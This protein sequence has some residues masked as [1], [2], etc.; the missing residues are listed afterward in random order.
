MNS[1]DFLYQNVLIPLDHNVSILL[2][3]NM[4]NGNIR[5]FLYRKLCLETWC[6]SKPLWKMLTLLV[7]FWRP[8][9]CWYL[10]TKMCWYSRPKCVDSSFKQYIMQLLRRFGLEY[11]AWK[12]TIVQH[13]ECCWFF[14]YNFLGQNFSDTFPSIHVLLTSSISL[15]YS[16]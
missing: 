3:S 12:V 2:V 11:Y 6:G 5:A 14:L 4:Y 16:S 1:T 9:P 13:L 10:Q 8:K 7:W 15:C